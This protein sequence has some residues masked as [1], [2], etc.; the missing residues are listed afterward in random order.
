MDGS[1]SGVVYEHDAD[2]RIEAQKLAREYCAYRG[3]GFPGSQ[4]VSMDRATG[5][6][7]MS[8]MAKSPYKVRSLID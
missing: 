3:K 5:F 7:N 4:P 1:V 2:L 8:F 6:D